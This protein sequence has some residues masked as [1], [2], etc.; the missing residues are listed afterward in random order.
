MNTCAKN[1]E[2]LQ[3]NNDALKELVNQ[4]Q[5]KPKISR[6]KE[7]IKIGTEIKLKPK[8]IQKIEKMKNRFFEKI[9]RINKPLARLRKERRSKYMTSQ[10]KRHNNGDHRN[11]KTH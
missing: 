11:T 8:K 9:K 4:T 7:I 2:G 1:V 5:T 10:I 3:I 6:R